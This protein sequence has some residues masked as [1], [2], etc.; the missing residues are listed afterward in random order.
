MFLSVSSEGC[1]NIS[2]TVDNFSA[3]GS[4][5]YFTGRGYALRVGVM[6]YR[7]RLCFTGRGYTVKAIMLPLIN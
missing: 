4:Y 1:T 2:I 5:K 6:L 3:N 7:S